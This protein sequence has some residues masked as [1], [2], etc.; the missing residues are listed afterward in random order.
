MHFFSRTLFICSSEISI[1]QNNAA[2]TL[3]QHREIL[4]RTEGN[5]C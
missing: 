5:V 3:V 2:A 1:H 4:E